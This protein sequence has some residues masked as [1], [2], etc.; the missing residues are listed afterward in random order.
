MRHLVKVRR[1]LDQLIPAGGRLDVDFDDARVG[2]DAK[3]GQTRVGG[4]L[5]TFEK[6]RRCEFLGRSLDSSDQFEIVLKTIR[7]RHENVEH[8]TARL[9]RYCRPCDV[10]RRLLAPWRAIIV[11]VRWRAFA[12]TRLGRRLKFGVLRQRFKVLRRIRCM[13]VGV[14]ALGHPGL[15]FERQTEA[16]RRVP[17][18]QEAAFAAQEPRAGLPASL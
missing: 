14:I 12:N 17:R 6:H 18:H 2:G 3:I 11:L 8:A 1:A 16:D 15:R 5:V 9:Y 4:R 10:R 13:G 7:R